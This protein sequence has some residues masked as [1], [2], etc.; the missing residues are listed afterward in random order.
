VSDLFM[1]LSFFFE[2]FDHGSNN[3]LQSIVR[4]L[5]YF[6][7]PKGPFNTIYLKLQRPHRLAFFLVSFPMKAQSPK[8][9]LV[10]VY[11]LLIDDNV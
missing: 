3:S 8:I 10:I 1:A 6:Y 4:N 11:D 5:V 9:S 2:I 7:L